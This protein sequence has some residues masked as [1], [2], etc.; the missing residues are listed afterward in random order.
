MIIIIWWI[1]KLD[2]WE[3]HVMY[4]CMYVYMTGSGWGSMMIGFATT[5]GGGTTE[6]GVIG[7]GDWMM[8]T[9]WEEH[10]EEEALHLKFQIV[11]G[12]VE[13]LL[14]ETACVVY[15]VLQL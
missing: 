9:E 4:A 13:S 12:I 3:G 6:G 11:E 15:S 7:G 10:E 5:A 8:M 14:E 2:L 1:A